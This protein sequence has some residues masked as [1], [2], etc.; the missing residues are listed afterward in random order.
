MKETGRRRLDRTAMGL[1]IGGNRLT[2]AASQWVTPM[3]RFGDTNAE[4]SADGLV[5][6]TSRGAGRIDARDGSGRPG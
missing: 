6:I 5:A 1:D 2:V 3:A 4:I